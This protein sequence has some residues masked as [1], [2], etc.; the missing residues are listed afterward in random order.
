MIVSPLIFVQIFFQVI[1]FLLSV[2]FT[3]KIRIDIIYPLRIVFF[4]SFL[5]ECI[6]AYY[7]KFGG[8]SFYFHYTYTLILYSAIAFFYSRIIRDKRWFKIIKLSM[9]VFYI[10]GIITIFKIE[11]FTYF[12]I[13]GALTVAMSVIF[14]LKELLL[15]DRILNYKLLLPFWVSV[16]FLVFYL[17][18]I[19]FIYLINYMRNRDLFPV[20]NILIILMNLFIIYG[21]ITCNK[22]EKY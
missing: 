8:S 19:P 12:F 9:M 15:S 5:V 7:V 18:S 10:I 1:T 21:L 22:E 16:G 13:I 2:F 6:G 17:P 20:L 11:L 3:K 4:F 14:Y